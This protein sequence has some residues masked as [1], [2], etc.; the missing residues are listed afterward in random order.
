MA[1]LRG[2]LPNL[3]LGGLLEH[4]LLYLISKQGI[5]FG[6]PTELGT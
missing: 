2:G 1:G 3:G 4:L 6:S 5:A